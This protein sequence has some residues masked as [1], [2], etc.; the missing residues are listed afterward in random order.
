MALEVLEDADPSQPCRRGSRLTAGGEQRGELIVAVEVTE[1][2]GDAEAE[3]AFGKSGVS[4]ALGLV[5]DRRQRL[6]GA[7]TWDGSP[8]AVR[9]RV[10]SYSLDPGS[11]R[12]YLA[13][14]KMNSPPVSLL[15]LPQPGGRF[16]L[17]VG[18]LSA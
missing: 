12:N 16:S 14:R 17:R 1:F 7:V 11:S 10:G 5:G 4:D 2:V 8:K 6:G 13:E 15:G 9:C 3:S 18:R